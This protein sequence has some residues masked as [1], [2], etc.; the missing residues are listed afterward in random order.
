[1]Y[2]IPCFHKIIK[3]NV[4]I[5]GLCIY[6]SFI[7][8]LH[9]LR[10]YGC[11]ELQ[12]FKAAL[13]IHF[14]FYKNVI[15]ETIAF[16][17]NSINFYMLRFSSKIF[18]LKELNIWRNLH[19]PG[20]IISWND[21]RGQILGWAKQFLSPLINDSIRLVNIPIELNVWIS[22]TQIESHFL[23][24]AFILFF[25]K[26]LI[27]YFKSIVKDNTRKC[28]QNCWKIPMKGL[29]FTKAIVPKLAALV[30]SDFFTRIFH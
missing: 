12:V 14:T 7:K 21:Q 11:Q 5:F 30:K 4:F 10:R 9:I 19:V 17:P 20:C 28:Q 8:Y 16:F 25:W 6:N 3:T 13:L 24:K 15:F 23:Q 2:R 26:S 1:M 29:N 27:L 22:N 18:T